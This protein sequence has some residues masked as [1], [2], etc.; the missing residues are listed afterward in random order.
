MKRIQYLVWVVAGMAA[1][2]ACKKGAGEGGDSTITGK[3]YAKDYNSSFNT[4]LGQ[5]YEK[6]EDVYIIY[7][8][9]V[10]IGDRTR[11][12]FDGTYQFKYLRP[13]KYKIFAYSKDSSG[14]YKNQV[15][16]NAPKKPVFKEVEITKSGSEVKVSDLVIL[17]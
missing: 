10:S 6:E 11:T 5:Y 9:D 14:A 16:V 4:L 1:L 8:D 2:S 7:G 3:V 15:N 12:S 17:K 13:G